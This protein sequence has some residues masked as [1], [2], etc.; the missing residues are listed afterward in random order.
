MIDTKPEFLYKY[1]TFEQFIDLIENSRLYFTNI[2]QWDDCYEGY[3]PNLY[4]KKVTSLLKGHKQEEETQNKRLTILNKLS[5]AQSWTEDNNESD[6]MWRIY[7]P[8]KTGV[9]IK[10]RTHLLKRCIEKINKCYYDFNS[11]NIIYKFPNFEQIDNINELIFERQ[12]LLYYKRNAF[13]HEKE[14]R[15]SFKLNWT[16]LPS[17]KN[18]D[19][20]CFDKIYHANLPKVIYYTIPNKYVDEIL[21]DPRAPEYFK[22]TF[23]KYCKNRGLDETK[24]SK[25]NLYTL[26]T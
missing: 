20:I 5:Y 17:I 6:A 10:I 15:F 8:N 3:S 2:L 13:K 11:G 12:S 14:Y 7:S 18:G 4:Y 1:I 22:E 25:S 21:L 9:R 19:S 16:N 26:Q 24:Y 23:F